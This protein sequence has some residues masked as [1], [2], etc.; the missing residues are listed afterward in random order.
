MS[1]APEQPGPVLSLVICTF[2]R[3]RLLGLALASVNAQAAPADF[4]V[5]IVVVDNSDECSARPT[6]DALALASQFPIRYVEAHPPN[7][8]VARNAGVAAAS[9]AAVAFLDDDQ[10][11][12]DGWLVAVAAALKELPHDAFF[13]AVEPLFEA[14]AEATAMARQLFSRRLDAPHGAE[15]VAFGPQKTRDIALATNNSIFRRASLPADCLFDLAFGNGGGEDYDLICRMQREG[16]RFAWLPDACAREFVPASRCEAG[17]LRRRFFAGGQAFAQ[18]VAN[19]SEHP[20][21]TRWSIRAK[22][23][24]QLALL[25][26]RTPLALARGQA[27]LTDHL[28]VFAGALGKL[29]FAEIKPIY[30]ETAPAR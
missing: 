17:Y 1:A 9:G 13:G 11:L 25:A 27:A 5:E 20:R 14:P 18:A 23:L 10:E 15:L 6:V 24:V 4:P 16:K 29:S 21:S 19:A 12:A 30:R 3:E 7:I 8:S 26:A 28:H 22:A 2:H